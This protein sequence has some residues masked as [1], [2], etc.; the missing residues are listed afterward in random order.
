MP[1]RRPK[2]RSVR[3]PTA[4]ATLG[5]VALLAATGCYAVQP[6]EGASD[7][8]EVTDA[9]AEERPTRDGGDLVMGLSAEPDVLDP[10]TSSS[11]YTRYVMNTIC[12]KL[13]DID[14]ENNL[15]PQLAAELPTLRDGGREVVIPLRRGIE[16]ADGEPFDAAAVKRTLERHLTK[17][18]S[19]RVSEM[20]PVTGVETPDDDTVV[21]TYDEPFAPITASL[22]DR[23]GMIMSPRA[24]AEL[25]DDFT[26]DPVCVGP[27]RF[28]E[29]VPQTSI[30]VEKDPNY[31]AADEVSL[32]TITYRIIT[33]ANI[34]AANLRAGEVQVVDAVSPQD[35]DS[36]KREDDIG[37]LQVGSLGYQG[38]TFNVGNAEGVGQ[39]PG[40][41]DSQ[42][43]S[44]RRV[45]QAFDLAVDRD[46][47]VNS[48]FNNWAEPA[49][50]G[51]APSTDFASKASNSCPAPDPEQSRALLR[52][53]GV[54]LPL[55][56]E[57]TVANTPDTLR[58]A[59]ALQA[60]VKEGGF[61][62][63]IQPVEYTTLLDQQDRGD[64]ESLQLGWS[65]RIDPN[66]NLDSFLITKQA[67][68]VAGYSNE[69]VDRLLATA[70]SQ[71]DT[72]ERA[73]TYSEAVHIVQRDLP[74]VYLY[75]LISLTGYTTDVTNVATYADGVVRLG[76]A[77][78]L[79]GE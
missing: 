49:C 21:I 75:R 18:D 44:D 53:A 54:E 2:D 73:Q 13:Y 4:A 16:F 60:M 14:A 56:I 35:V 22:A 55:E 32:D 63:D 70:S 51:I 79:A 3:R 10:T 27:F 26:E 67:N 33:D 61:D 71:V 57:M 48:V 72:E 6:R 30:T 43:A 11:L 37:V 69:R 38:V 42:V 31:Y 20:G 40:E 7:R 1:R 50:S 66:G 34:R 9:T 19:A 76:R 78:Y 8:A 77:A 25:G 24:L 39:P 62:V 28:V 15:V 58:L 59:Q 45:R 23:A 47:I 52:E 68:N 74:I 36:L 5:L 46:A 41:V 29:R 64:F 12:E 17:E 65:G